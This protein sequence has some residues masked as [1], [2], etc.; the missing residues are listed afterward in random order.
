MVIT[1]SGGVSEESTYFNV[2]CV[3]L[4]KNTERPETVTDGTNVLLDFTDINTLGK[5]IKLAEEGKWKKSQM[6]A[7]WDGNTGLRII[8]ELEKLFG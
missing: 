2:P 8:T 5:Y 4:R 7:L 3:T 1:D 6:P